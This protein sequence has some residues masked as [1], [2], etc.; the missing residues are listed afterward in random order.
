MKRRRSD[1]DELGRNSK[2]G[3]RG[4]WS[5]PAYLAVDDAFVAS[6]GVRQMLLRSRG[7]VVGQMRKRVKRRA[8]LHAEQTQHGQ[9]GNEP[10]N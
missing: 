6:I 10:G 2:R 4:G 1:D 9:D 5:G 8:L 7:I 3:V